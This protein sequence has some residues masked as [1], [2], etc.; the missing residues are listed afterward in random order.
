MII[1]K[2]PQKPAQYSINTRNVE[3]ES[4]TGNKVNS[5][6]GVLLFVISVL[7]MT[8]TAPIGF[9]YGLFYEIYRK[10]WDGMGEYCLK[11]AVSIDQLGNVIMQ[12]LLNALWITKD[13]YKFGNPDETISSAIGKNLEKGTLTPFGKF[14]DRFLDTIDPNHSLNSIDYY[15][16]PVEDDKQELLAEDE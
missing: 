11:V 10:G 5:L 13:G 7:L 14:I 15:I 4:T 2:K 12:H 1:K 8:V 9:L 16:Q 3:L 6:I